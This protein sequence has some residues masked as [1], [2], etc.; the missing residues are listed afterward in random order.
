MQT[1]SALVLFIIALTLATQGPQKS[2]RL[3]DSVDIAEK[4]GLTVTNVFGGV[5][6]REY[7]I[8]T[9]AQASQFSITTTMAGPIFS[10]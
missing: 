3:A 2:E 10:S 5:D 6:T 8:E 1:L 4:G 9:K 7:I